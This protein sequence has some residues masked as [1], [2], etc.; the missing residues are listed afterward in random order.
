[1]NEARIASLH[2]YPVKGC[3]GLDLA[4]APLTQTGLR[5]DREWMFVNEAGRFLTQRECAGLARIDVEVNEDELVLSSSGHPSLHCD[6]ERDARGKQRQ[7]LIWRDT[8]PARESLTD[9]RAW[10]QSAAGVSGQLVRVV[11]EHERIC[12][13]A[14]TGADQ[15]RAY[16]S[17]AYPALITNPAS[18]AALNERLPEPLPMN[19]FRPNIV[20]EGLEPFDEDRMTW[21]HLGSAELK[22]VKPCLRCIVTTTDQRSGERG[23]D[24][25]LHTL[26][27]FR[28]LTS[29]RGV[30]FGMNAIV[31]R[32]AGAELQAG[33]GVDVSWH[34]ESEPARWVFQEVG[35]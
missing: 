4:R 14:F 24:E 20:L 6:L 33:Q 9:T 26:R 31:T 28:W 21:L 7:V 34:P 11:A 25:P 32:G 10:L 15:G 35:A 16:F 12:D 27:S 22:C 5:W 1:M 18:L 2:V 13:P 17:D 23:G 29:L 8:C 30:A 3:R 19:R